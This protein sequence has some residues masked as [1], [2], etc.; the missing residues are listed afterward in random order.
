MSRKILLP[1]EITLCHEVGLTRKEYLDF[2]AYKNQ[3][4]RERLAAPTGEIRAAF[5]PLIIAIVGVV[6]QIAAQL[7]APRPKTD[8]AGSQQERFSPTFGF[9]SLQELAQYGQP[10]FLVYGD[11]S[12][13][14]TGGVRANTQLVF[15]EILS[16]G[17]NQF[18]RFL[19]VVCSGSLAEINLDW[20][21]IGD[22]P[23]SELPGN[24][25]W[26]YPRLGATLDERPILANGSD[27]DDPSYLANPGTHIYELRT[28]AD[29]PVDGFSQAYQPTANRSI[30]IFAF[31]P[32]NIEIEADTSS[33]GSDAMVGILSDTEWAA[34]QTIAIG[35]SLLITIQSTNFN[36]YFETNAG[37]AAA[38]TIRRNAIDGID[39]GSQ[40]KLGT[41]K[42]DLESL[43]PPGRATTDDGQ[44]LVVFRCTEGGKFPTTAYSITTT[45]NNRAKGMV[46]VEIGRYS[47]IT[48]SNIIDFCLKAQI[49]RN[50]QGRTQTSQNGYQ[51]RQSFFE[52]YYKLQSSNNWI[53]VPG[54]FAIRSRKPVDLYTFLKFVFT[55]Q[56][57]WEFRFEPVYDVGSFEI[58]TIGG[59]S[60]TPAGGALRLEPW[61]VAQN[62]DHPTGNFTNMA[63]AGGSGTGLRITVTI[64]PSNQF[65]YK[66]F[67]YVSSVIIIDPGSSYQ[68]GDLVSIVTG[69]KNLYFVVTNVPNATNV[70]A[71]A[72]VILENNGGGYI[73]GDFTD[74][75][76]RK[77][78]FQPGQGAKV[79]VSI[80]GGNIQSVT[81]V[82]GGTGYSNSDLFTIWEGD[83][84]ASSP[85]IGA[86]R[87]RITALT[88]TPDGGSSS[89][90]GG[91]STYKQINYIDSKGSGQIQATP[92]GSVFWLGDK[93]NDLISQ[94]PY[95]PE[96]GLIDD[97]N[98]I[99][100]SFDQGP[101]IEISAVNEQQSTTTPALYSQ[102]AM[103][104]VNVYAG[105]SLQDLTQISVFVWRGKIIPKLLAGGVGPTCFFPEI[106]W[107]LYTDSL[108]GLGNDVPVE[109]LDRTSFEFATLFCQVNQ[110]YC[111]TAIVEII[112]IREFASQVGQFSLLEYGVVDG[113]ESLQP[114]LPTDAAGN[115]VQTVAISNAFNEGNILEGT[116]KEQFLDYAD[117]KPFQAK[118]IFRDGTEQ[119]ATK[120]TVI[121][122]PNIVG[123]ELLPE[124]SFDLS[125]SVTN[126]A[127]ATKYGKYVVNTRR[128]VT[129]SVEFQTIPDGA[130]I[131]PGDYILIYTEMMSWDDLTTG[132]V[133]ING[134]LNSPSLPPTYAA[135]RDILLYKS[136]ELPLA[137]SDYA[138]VDCEIDPQYAGSLFVIGTN[139]QHSRCFKI[140]EIEASEEGVYTVRAT[141]FPL[142]SSGNSLIADFSNSL[143]Q[144]VNT[145][146]VSTAP[147]ITLRS[148]ILG[149]S[150]Y[151]YWDFS[152]SSI[153]GTTVLDQSV[154]TR[155]GLIWNTVAANSGFVDITGTGKITQVGSDNSLASGDLTVFFKFKTTENNTGLF[156]FTNSDTYSAS[157]WSPAIYI[158]GG[159]LTVYYF[160]SSTFT[161]NTAT[162]V[163]DGLWHTFSYTKSASGHSLYLDNVLINTGASAPLFP[164]NGYMHFGFAYGQ[165]VATN[166]VGSLDECAV[167]TTPL[168]VPQIQQMHTLS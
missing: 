167:F 109:S 36:D 145:V 135:T 152:P 94:T 134:H 58:V 48:P 143:F 164:F 61:D 144:I 72:S 126:L 53:K 85:D 154:N 15:S 147:V 110:L 148:Y 162:A 27:P 67:P 59:G 66:N 87:I 11:R 165:G 158:S 26:L 69:N 115:I 150:P 77:I 90:G 103:F 95:E 133:E 19:S 89:G 106:L 99:Q 50:V 6:L 20:S 163:S 138:I 159:N 79:N 161:I 97:D 136:G 9:S 35:D 96:F 3:L 71:I 60:G 5:A 117:V 14:P 17:G 128:Y 168:T 124:Q 45:E 104:G 57:Q 62:A 83:L 74:I 56:E 30:G 116:Y 28:D 76:L 105:M 118:V 125:A 21:A 119:F 93:R 55:T 4:T 63:A 112:N 108:N 13:N 7:L 153:T 16:Y 52:A 82:R 157:S 32:I 68:L 12:V 64:N 33:G 40:Y 43:D 140:N 156:S 121:V 46:K 100:Y 122:R 80:T 92:N 41:A 8:Q 78:N 146:A 107:D 84:R 102:Y 10:V 65:L 47:T 111:D 123:A 130:G 75:P 39:F 38:A 23:F 131:A 129:S 155:N 29:S 73:N 151:F 49:Y 160:T 51:Y 166:F 44:M 113:K 34:G 24:R 18:G 120:S 31:F 141:L 142:D 88:Q 91:S 98:Y 137:L 81:L 25:S 42:F 132:F 139:T 54:T 2:L 149:L 22:T 86:A 114:A 37:A 70:N 1:Y 101:E 127:Q